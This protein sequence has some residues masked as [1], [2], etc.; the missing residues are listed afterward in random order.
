MDGGGARLFLNERP[1]TARPDTPNRK[2]SPPWVH[3]PKCCS[4]RRLAPALA[5]VSVAL[6]QDQRSAV[7]CR[8]R[9]IEM[10]Q[11]K[12]A[13]RRRARRAV[14]RDLC[15]RATKRRGTDGRRSGWAIVPEEKKIKPFCSSFCRR[16]GARRCC[17]SS[18]SR[19]CSSSIDWFR[20][21]RRRR[22]ARGS[23][24]TGARYA[25]EQSH[26]I[27]TAWLSRS[28]TAT[29]RRW[30]QT[31]TR[32]LDAAPR[33]LAAVDGWRHRDRAAGPSRRAPRVAD[34]RAARRGFEK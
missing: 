11:K 7:G 23:P 15:S 9:P 32:V 20:V 8:L 33:L 27:D 18:P 24:N 6:A 16:F 30:N 13:W 26:H 17:Q 34:A 12:Q 1:A 22:C 3:N 31:S 4:A 29:R 19:G 21:I 10:S 5:L 14:Q 28:W 2:N 25:I